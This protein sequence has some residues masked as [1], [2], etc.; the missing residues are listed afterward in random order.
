MAMH[1][2]FHSQL[3]GWMDGLMIV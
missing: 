2:Y 3:A 1:E